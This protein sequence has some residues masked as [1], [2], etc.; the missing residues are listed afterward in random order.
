MSAYRALRAM[1]RR[2]P[3]SL[4]DAFAQNA[5]L[6]EIKLSIS[7]LLMTHDDIYDDEYYDSFEFEEAERSAG[8]IARSILRDFAPKMVLDVGCG[9]GAMLATLAAQGIE[10][11]GLE[12]SEAALKHCHR[13]GLNVRKFDLESSHPPPIAPR[14]D[15]V[16]C[17]EVAEHLP[18]HLADRLVDFLTS[19]GRAVVFSAATP[20]QGGRDHVNEQPHE[21]WIEKFAE[22]RFEHAS[23][24]S[25][26]WRAEWERQGTAWWY[27]RNLMLFRARPQ[28]VA[29]DEPEP[30]VGPS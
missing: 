18:S 26:A 23:E 11:A 9:T 2:L 6:R 21:Y 14:F 10:V 19:H 17:L 4:R 20:G 7:G 27:F 24:L 8:P 28:V 30:P 15:L 22:R 13:R 29:A 3:G 5:V 16:M 25:L 12:Y 1:W